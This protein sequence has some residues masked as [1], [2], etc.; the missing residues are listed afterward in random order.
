VDGF[1]GHDGKEASQENKTS[2]IPELWLTDSLRGRILVVMEIEVA[3]RRLA[4]LGHPA[5]LEAFRLL[6]RAGCDGLAVNEIQAH[7]GIP[8]S[9]LSHH[10]SH[11]LAAGLIN[12]TREGRVLRCRVDYQ[13]IKEVLRYLMEDCCAGVV[14]G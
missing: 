2:I 13:A 8:Q 5:R 3:A 9:T 10:I 6:I 7:L 4:E 12:Q 14:D 11:L 1:A